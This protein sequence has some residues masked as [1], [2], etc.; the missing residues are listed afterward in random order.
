MQRSKIKT[1]IQKLLNQ[2]SQNELTELH[3]LIVRRYALDVEV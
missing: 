1:K 3:Q 2:L